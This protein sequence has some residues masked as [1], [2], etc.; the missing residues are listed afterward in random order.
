MS[1]A[2]LR[3]FVTPTRIALISL[4]PSTRHVSSTPQYRILELDRSVRVQESLSECAYERE[5]LF[6]EEEV[7]ALLSV[8]LNN[9][10]GALKARKKSDAAE[11]IDE[12]RNISSEV[13]VAAAE[14]Q[15]GGGGGGSAPLQTSEFWNFS[16]YFGSGNASSSSSMGSTIVNNS[17]S[18]S[19]SASTSTSTSTFN[20]NGFSPDVESVQTVEAHCLLGAV[21]FLR[22]F[23]LLL[24]TRVEQVG[25]IGPHKVFAI[26]ATELLP[27]FNDSTLAPLP[28]SSALSSFSSLSGIGGP[29]SSSNNSNTSAPNASSSSSSSSLAASAFGAAGAALQRLQDRIGG[30]SDLIA[31]A[32]ERYLSLMLSV[33]LTKGDFFFSRTYDLTRPLQQQHSQ[34]SSL[35]NN[36]TRRP[37][38]R[39][40]WNQFLNSEL[41]VMSASSSSSSSAPSTSSSSPLSSSWKV[42]LL[43]GFFRQVKMS[44]F[45]RPFILSLIARRSR[46]YAGTR[47]LKRGVNSLGNVANEV[48]SEQ[49]VDDTFG[50]MSSFCQVRGSVPTYW[51]QETS[52]AVPKPPV[53][54]QP[55]DHSFEPAKKHAAGLLS[56]YG[57][58]LM[59]LNLVKKREK[60]GSEREKLVGRE[61]ARVAMA[62][63]ADLPP[64]LRIQYLALDYDSVLKKRR[65]VDFLRDA[66]LWALSNCG[67][68]CSAEQRNSRTLPLARNVNSS[69]SSLN[70]GEE[71]NERRYTT[72]NSIPN[73]LN[74][75]QTSGD[76]LRSIKD[77]DASA[78]VEMTNFGTASTS[79]ASL[80]SLASTVYIAPNV[81]SAM[82]PLSYLAEQNNQTAA[83]TTG[84]ASSIPIKYRKKQNPYISR[85]SKYMTVPSV[86]IV[87]ELEIID[88]MAAASTNLLSTFRHSSLQA[89]QQQDDINNGGSGSLNNRIG[90]PLP[91]L[92]AWAGQVP[93]STAA[94]NT[95]AAALTLTTK[96]M[97]TNVDPASISSVKSADALR[98]L[99]R[100]LRSAGGVAA[101][102]RVPPLSSEPLSSDFE[103]MDIN[104][105]VS[106]DMKSSGISSSANKHQ[107]RGRDV[108]GQLKFEDAA[109]EE[110]FSK[111]VFVAE[112]A[113]SAGAA[114]S[115]IEIPQELVPFANDPLK[116]D[117]V[118]AENTQQQDSEDPEAIASSSP[119]SVVGLSDD[120]D[121]NEDDDSTSSDSD[122][123]ERSERK[124][125]RQD[126]QQG[127]D[128]NLV[129]GKRAPLK[130][131]ASSSES[132]HVSDTI[133]ATLASALGPTM[134]VV[135]TTGLSNVKSTGTALLTTA[136]AAASHKSSS[137]FSF[138]GLFGGISSTSTVS[139]TTT[140]KEGQKGPQSSSSSTSNL[141][142]GSEIK[143]QSEHTDLSNAG[144]SS[145]TSQASSSSYVSFEDLLGLSS[146][147]S[148]N[149]S[150]SSSSL[151]ISSNSSSGTSS[152][153]HD[154]SSSSISMPNSS[155]SVPGA[156]LS[157]VDAL[158][159]DRH[160]T[161]TTETRSVGSLSHL[162][163]DADRPYGHLREISSAASKCR[164]VVACSEEQDELVQHSQEKSSSSRN[165][166]SSSSSTDPNVGIAARIKSYHYEGGEGEYLFVNLQGSQHG[167]KWVQDVV[168]ALPSISSSH[169]SEVKKRNREKV[170]IDEMSSTPKVKI[171]EMSSTPSA[172]RMQRG[173]LRTNCVD[174]LDRT[175]VGQANVGVYALGLQLRSLGLADESAEPSSSIVETYFDLFTAHGD[176]IALQYGGSEAN[177]KMTLVAYEDSVRRGGSSTGPDTQTID[178]FAPL[179]SSMSSS[180]SSNAGAIG[181]SL[182]V[183]S[184]LS[185]SGAAIDSRNVTNAAAIAA[186]SAAAAASSASSSIAQ[187]TSGGMAKLKLSSSGPS[188][189]LTSVKRYVSNAFTDSLKQASI[190]LFLGVWR[191]KRHTSVFGGVHLWD[192]ES[193]YLLHNPNLLS[194]SEESA[195]EGILL[196]KEEE[197]E[198]GSVRTKTECDDVDSRQDDV[199][200]N[201]K[202][203][204]ET[205]LN[206]FEMSTFKNDENNKENDDDDDNGRR[207]IDN[208]SDG[209]L[210]MNT[211]S[212]R[213]SFS[214]HAEDESSSS[215]LTFFESVLSQPH[216]APLPASISSSSLLPI[217]SLTSLSTNVS[218]TLP[219]IPEASVG[220]DAKDAQDSSSA[221]TSSSSLS[222]SGKQLT[223]SNEI[224]K[225][226]STV[227][228]FDTMSTTNAVDSVTI[229]RKGVEGGGGGGAEPT[230]GIEKARRMFGSKLRSVLHDPKHSESLFADVL[231]GLGGG[232]RYHD[233]HHHHHQPNQH[234]V[235]SS[236][237]HHHQQQY[238]HQSF[239]GSVVERAFGAAA[240]IVAR[241][242]T[243]GNSIRRRAGDGLR[244]ESLQ[245]ILGDSIF[246]STP[247]VTG[248]GGLALSEGLSTAYNAIK[249]PDTETKMTTFP[250]LSSSSTT[251]FSPSPL[252]MSSPPSKIVDSIDALTL[253]ANTS[254]ASKSEYPLDQSQRVDAKF[255]SALYNN[256][257][258]TKNDG[259]SIISSSLSKS[260]IPSISPSESDANTFS[261]YVALTGIISP[262][263]SGEAQPTI[264]TSGKAATAADVGSDPPA[265]AIRRVAAPLL[266]TSKAEIDI[267]SRSVIFPGLGAANAA[268]QSGIGPGD[269][270]I[271]LGAADAGGATASLLQSLSE[272]SSLTQLQKW[273]LMHPLSLNPHF[274]EATGEIVNHGIFADEPIGREASSKLLSSYSRNLWQREILYRA[275]LATERHLSHATGNGD[276]DNTGLENLL[277]KGEIVSDRTDILPSTLGLI[278][279]TAV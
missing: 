213:N 86:Q 247:S 91:Q 67:F 84:T 120:E 126:K 139:T 231:G 36:T 14:I 271:A 26:R 264:S 194:N 173:V 8:L 256:N 52:I 119:G 175:N 214:W 135:T 221:L 118:R 220:L 252:F 200:G 270:A 161:G 82:Q 160:H 192:L 92:L 74:F 1:V 109:N 80:R 232:H 23:Y 65:R 56:R 130:G 275:S 150:S 62:L 19:S 215:S 244:S 253:S 158:D 98:T 170:K 83:R 44:A 105:D 143:Q 171:D 71:S 255:L 131:S 246:A 243:V 240:S 103:A 127:V 37:R 187:A 22:G 279:V 230:T 13:G 60:R 11:K 197:V 100:T 178:T 216:L 54:L 259:A 58:P 169:S 235:D 274:A 142:I 85:L 195:A 77:N 97:S 28:A 273:Y 6:S 144:N 248:R 191:P 20:N 268:L 250:N 190:N 207:N 90:S 236:F 12:S 33:D 155:N 21:Q 148:N 157:L 198:R 88:S 163:D 152:H 257:N 217:P 269:L 251:A 110:A 172:S 265:P 164:F 177:K 99:E 87:G 241:A 272:S 137:I 225:S 181:D 124:K 211:S 43:H 205:P 267:F 111:Q 73:L 165:I 125:K 51:M 15:G 209:Q 219:T 162:R 147:S 218:Q 146:S 153:T 201:N 154:A 261:R 117:D 38:T 4:E 168:P 75:E 108:A 116:H 133:V 96:S 245:Q 206:S 61:M 196:D 159:L 16:S 35:N 186:S 212:R 210:L 151:K 141:S 48:E 63:N 66:A 27:V 30:S 89:Y 132:V 262:S 224:S 129:S 17:S 122:E 112:V 156:P 57:A 81:S 174:C 121:D 228:V 93:I 134:S 7:S 138:Q 115:L 179:P 266:S 199:V 113:A 64:H 254:L 49:I 41:R 10:S 69:L 203:W 18:S 176:A 70:H 47:Y 106:F 180:T 233:H 29:I 114:S 79:N 50:R 9:T 258:G 25:L 78:A 222:L 184:G 2:P 24:A 5:G 242:S 202:G 40:I 237:H 183:P 276:S 188:Q 204:W 107:R 32:E 234:Q 260:F 94:A 102:T 59:I 185:G 182:T 3:L 278:F 167:V 34:G 55:R 95:A 249:S 166:S 263:E 227:V 145:S 128:D 136:T 104:G 46:F 76:R 149:S 277:Q 39:F 101:I 31:I 140:S 239:D 123:E 189:V 226:D 238:H 68:F 42:N 53:L 208:S 72:D 223:A 45:G 229:E 193:D